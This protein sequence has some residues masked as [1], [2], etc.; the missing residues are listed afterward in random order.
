M[1]GIQKN[2]THRRDP[3]G[4]VRTLQTSTIANSANSWANH[5]RKSAVPLR[6]ERGVGYFGD[7]LDGWIPRRYLENIV[8][9][10]IPEYL[11]LRG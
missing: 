8:Y 10:F 2:V 4:A 5:W 6:A 3:D 11:V 7:K 9:R 1:I